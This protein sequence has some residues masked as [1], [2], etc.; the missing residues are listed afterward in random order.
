M[1]LKLIEL[2]VS[3]L[4]FGILYYNSVLCIII[5]MHYAVDGPGLQPREPRGASLHCLRKDY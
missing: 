3:F 5:M 2:L 4:L 1:G